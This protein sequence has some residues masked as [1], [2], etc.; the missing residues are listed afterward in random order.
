MIFKHGAIAS[1]ELRTTSCIM[2][3]SL[4]KFGFCCCDKILIIINLEKER[5]C[6]A[7]SLQSINKGSQCR[8]SR[9]DLEAEPETEM[10][11]ER[12]SL[13]APIGSLGYSPYAAQAH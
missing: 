6:V 3:G 13:A 2:A 1:L 5:V 8:N 7:Y 9:R 11:K 10:V 4:A 12:C